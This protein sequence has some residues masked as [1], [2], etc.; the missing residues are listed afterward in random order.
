M[1]GAWRCCRFPPPPR[2]PPEKA[3]PAVDTKVRPLHIRDATRSARDSF[4]RRCACFCFRL[5]TPMDCLGR[6]LCRRRPLALCPRRTSHA[7]EGETCGRS[8]P[9]VTRANQNGCRVTV[10]CVF[11]DALV[12]LRRSPSIRCTALRRHRQ[13]CT[14][15]PGP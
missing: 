9:A 2:I 3:K 11:P 12:N 7:P 1:K 13:K 6:D 8:N 14:S 4:T 5:R 15:L 10:L